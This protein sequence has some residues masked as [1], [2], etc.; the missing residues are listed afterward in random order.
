MQSSDMGEYTSIALRV[1][2]GCCANAFSLEYAWLSMNYPAHRLIYD[3]VPLFYQIPYE[4]EC[5]LGLSTDV[6]SAT[7]HRCSII[8]VIH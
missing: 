4:S 5:C 3:T 2:G 7:L 1:Y 6:L 8:T